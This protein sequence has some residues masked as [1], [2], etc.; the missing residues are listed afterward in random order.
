MTEPQEES[1]RD[2][3]ASVAE[4]GG[5]AL[6]VLAAFLLSLSLGFAA[7]GVGLFAVGFFGLAS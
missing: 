2:L 1:K 3:W 4:V 5:I 7:A 6:V